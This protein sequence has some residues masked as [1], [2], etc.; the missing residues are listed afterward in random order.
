MEPF[1]SFDAALTHVTPGDTIH[2]LPTTAYLGILDYTT[3]GT[4]GN[5]IT[6]TG[7]G[8]APNLTEVTTD[9]SAT[10]AWPQS[11]YPIYLYGVSYVNVTNLDV[12]G[13]PVPSDTCIDVFNSNHINISD[14]YTHGCGLDGI[15]TEGSDYVTVVD[16]IVYDNSYNT[17]NGLFG[18]GI[19]TFEMVDTDSDIKN[20]KIHILGNIVYNNANTPRS[21][22][23]MLDLKPTLNSDG[24]CQIAVYGSPGFP[25]L[26]T[27]AN[28]Y[29]CNPSAGDKCCNGDECALYEYDSDG[30]GIIIDINAETSYKGRTLVANN[31]IY[32]NGGRGVTI[33]QSGNVTV[34]D[35]TI[36]YNNQ[37]PY[38]GVPRAGE[39]MLTG[40][41]GSNYIYNNILYSDDGYT[42]LEPGSA[43]YTHVPFSCV[44]NTT[45]SLWYKYNLI[46]NAPNLQ[47]LNNIAQT[48]S[49]QGCNV[50]FMTLTEQLWGNP[51]FIDVSGST[52]YQI[53]PNFAAEN[54]TH[55]VV[56]GPAELVDALVAEFTVA[57]VRCQRLVVSHAFHSALLDPMLDELEAAAA[58]EHREASLALVSNLTGTAFAAGTHPDAAY[59]RRHARAPVRFAEGVATLTG[60]RV[61]VLVELGP[62][63]VLG[64][65][66]LDCWPWESAPVVLSSLRPGVADEWALAEAVA[67]LYAAG[68]SIDFGSREAGRGR[69]RIALPGYP[70]ERTRHWI[71]APKRRGR[72]ATERP[73]LGVE[74]RLASGEVSWTQELSATE[75]G[76]V[77]DHA[78]FGSVVIPG[79]LHACLAAATEAAPVSVRDGVIH[80]P[81]VLTEQPVEVQLLLSAPEET[82]QRGWRVFAR[83]VGSAAETP[84]RLHASGRVGRAGAMPDEPGLALAGLRERDVGEFYAS[85]ALL[86]IGYGP[87]FERVERLWSE[88]GWRAARL[89]RWRAWRISE[90][91]CIRRCWTPASRC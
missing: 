67:G 27:A 32:N 79:A 38:G 73:L 7:D 82:G 60:M 54:G 52:T 11:N 47:K 45:G 29:C 72:R 24:V 81:L 49:M 2:L 5:P 77:V 15:S 48:I 16:N 78:V 13:D 66:A 3:S 62:R 58:V 83:A 87:S 68:G 63:P 50:N 8:V 88:A 53:T 56:S 42:P 9:T 4:P 33:N 91:G 12:S 35:N 76:W 6:V 36:Y 40:A 21:T 25:T 22:S 61:D 43:N 90:R 86:G 17:T 34:T 31:V 37:D 23:N 74:H 89:W 84:W 28:G 65:L 85:I 18:S 46:Y 80:A 71:E 41:V 30:S 55:R 51:D 39:I 26:T 64:P 14:N 20:Y 57:G 44:N 75:P 10:G 1:L 70:F 59:W 69:R 19:S